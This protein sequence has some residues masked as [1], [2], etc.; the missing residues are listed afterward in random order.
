MLD[1]YFLSAVDT[2]EP[3][4]PRGM[5]VLL[6]GLLDGILEAPGGREGRTSREAPWVAKE[7]YPSIVVGICLA[8]FCLSN[9]R[10]PGNVAAFSCQFKHRQNGVAFMLK[11]H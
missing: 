4:V 10:G 3:D 5:N 7:G 11:P 9:H 2:T 6:P 1:A 8:L